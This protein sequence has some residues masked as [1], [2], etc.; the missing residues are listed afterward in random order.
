MCGKTSRC[1]FDP[2]PRRERPHLTRIRF[3]LTQVG[4]NRLH[5]L[6]YAPVYPA[7]DP[8]ADLLEDPLSGIQL[9]T[10]CRLDDRCHS[11]IPYYLT[12]VT[13]RSTP[14]QRLDVRLMLQAIDSHRYSRRLH[15]IDPT[16]QQLAPPNVYHQEQ[17]HPLVDQ[18]HSLMHLHSTTTPHPTDHPPQAHSHLIGKAKG[19]LRTHARFGKATTKPPFFHDSCA[20]TSAFS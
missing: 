17:V 8:P 16:P 4:V 3:K 5:L 1:V 10:I 7:L 12:P 14:H 15:R 6:I 13:T 20:A 18:L 9:R 19:R 2:T 11:N